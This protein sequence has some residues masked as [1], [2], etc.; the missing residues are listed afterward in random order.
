MSLNMATG[1]FFYSPKKEKNEK[2][3]YFLYFVVQKTTFSAFSKPFLIFL[4]NFTHKRCFFLF[5]E[6]FKSTK[7]CSKQIYFFPK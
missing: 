4:A 5:L 7:N 1:I 3:K 6:V 2:K